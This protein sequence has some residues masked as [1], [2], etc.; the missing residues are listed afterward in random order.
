MF[1][2][3]RPRGACVLKVGCFGIPCPTTGDTGYPGPDTQRCAE[4]CMW[5]V[6]EATN[7]VIRERDLVDTKDRITKE[8]H[9]KL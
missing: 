7:E 2:E 4:G 5:R 8:R 1:A 9:E 3:L 6:D